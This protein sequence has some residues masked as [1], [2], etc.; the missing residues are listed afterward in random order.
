MVRTESARRLRDLQQLQGL[1][2]SQAPR[3]ELTQQLDAEVAAREAAE[4]KLREA[5]ASLARQK[6]LMADLRK[7]VSACTALISSSWCP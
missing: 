1:Q 6:Q 7:K 3:P 2:V 4:A 5:R